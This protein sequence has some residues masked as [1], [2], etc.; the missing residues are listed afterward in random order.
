MPQSFGSVAA[1]RSGTR[2]YP[3]SLAPGFLISLAM[4]GTV[5]GTCLATGAI[6]DTLLSASDGLTSTRPRTALPWT[7]A[8][9]NARQPPMERPKT[10]VCSHQL[11]SA[12]NAAST[13]AYQ[14]CQPVRAR[15]CQVVPCPGSLGRLTVQPWPAT[16]SA[17]VRSVCGLPVK[18]W[19]NSTPTGPPACSNG[20]APGSSAPEIDADMPS[21]S[22][23]LYPYCPCRSRYLTN[24]S[25]GQWQP[26]PP[27]GRV[28]AEPRGTVDAGETNRGML[29]CLPR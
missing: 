4:P 6:R 17:H 13:S 10:K 29:R 14:S 8:R 2:S 15:S 23:I 24:Y 28:P 20:S 27:R 12:P 3:T 5:H 18:P 21:T 7:S 16:C 11:A 26:S 25:G 19:H 1:A 22:S 9:R